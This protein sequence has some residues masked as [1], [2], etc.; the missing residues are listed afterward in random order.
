VNPNKGSIIVYNNS[1]YHVGTGP[2]PSGNAANYACINAYDSNG[3]PTVN[4]EVYNNTCYDP[5]SRGASEGDAGGY[6]FFIPTRMRNNVTYALTGE[7]Y[8][9]NSAK[10]QCVGCTTGTNNLWY[11]VGAGPSQ[12][13]G[14]IN[15]DP[16][17]VNGSA[18]NFQLQQGSPAIGAGVAI[19]GLTMDI[20]GTARAQSGT[21]DVGAFQYA[22]ATTTTSPCDLNGDG[23][24]NQTD[25]NIAMSQALGTSACTNAALYQSGVCNVVDVQR[26]INASQGASCRV[27]M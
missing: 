25:V 24:V 17:F 23:V 14:N 3:T 10:S 11:G 6:S 2:D 8:F 5:G 4:V 9:T 22:A 15:A 19:A 27:G 13:T 16:L 20:L 7:A 1:M 26:V 18:A 21:V 12:T